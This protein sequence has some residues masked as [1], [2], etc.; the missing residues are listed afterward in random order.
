MRQRRFA[1]I[2][3]LFL[4]LGLIGA[5][6]GRRT[7]QSRQDAAGGASDA[8]G[9]LPEDSVPG[10]RGAPATAAQGGVPAPPDPVARQ[11]VD[12][13]QTGPGTFGYAPGA[14]PVLGGGGTLRPFQ[15]AV[16]DGTGQDAA[17][18]ASAAE[19]ILGDPNSWI[20][21]GAFRFQR[22]PQGAPSDF[23]LMLATPATSERLCAEGGLRTQRYT[24]CRLSGR[25]IINL[26]RWMTAVPDY[27][28]PLEVYRAYA[29]NHEVGHQLGKGHELCPGKGQPAPVM[30]QQTFGLKGC[31]A[32][33]WPIVNGRSYNGPNAP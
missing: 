14:G 6:L 28:A 33:A 8:Q 27:G 16:E 24:S 19:A 22:V 12:V 9:G 21:T 4:V 26:A 11:A 1:G 29:I 25:V 30:Q 5:E 13:P 23:T 32:N 18:F 15:V 2:V 7:V 10:R 20:G 31:V 3:V 17:A